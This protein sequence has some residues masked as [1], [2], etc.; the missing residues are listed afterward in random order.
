MRKLVYLFQ[1]FIIYTILTGFILKK[2]NEDKVRLN[3]FYEVNPKL[4]V[5]YKPKIYDVKQKLLINNLEFG[6]IVPDKIYEI[7]NF[8]FPIRLNLQTKVLNK[9]FGNPG[10]LICKNKILNEKYL[11]SITTKNIN[12]EISD[13]F[14]IIRTKNEW[15]INDLINCKLPKI[16]SVIHE[17]TYDRFETEINENKYIINKANYKKSFVY[18]INENKSLIRKKYKKK[19]NK[20]L[21]HIEKECKVHI[22]HYPTLNDCVYSKWRIE[23]GGYYLKT[24]DLLYNNKKLEILLNDNYKFDKI[25]PIIIYIRNLIIQNKDVDVKVS[26]IN[27]NLINIM[28]E[29]IKNET[30]KFFKKKKHDMDNCDKKEIECYRE[31]NELITKSYLSKIKIF[32]FDINFKQFKT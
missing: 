31:L 16:T 25:N 10:M 8:K 14:L 3:F 30:E 18:L 7:K 23:T 6:E 13:I 12:Y 24:K 9:T 11:E 17:V 22:Q 21:E 15:S 32:K 29:T 5:I 2:E 28:Q 27:R 20:M 1:L 19:F 26:I 4:H